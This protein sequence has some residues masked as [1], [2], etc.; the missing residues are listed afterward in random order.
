MKD[1]E[2][3]AQ[4][5]TLRDF[6]KTP[7]EIEA[8]LKRVKA[9]G[10]NYV[11]VSGIGAISHE[12]MRRILDQTGLKVCATH[13]SFDRIKSN[14]EEVIYQHRLWECPNIGIGMMPMEYNRSETGYTK[15][16]KEASEIGKKLAEYGFRF[17]YHNHKVEFEKYNG[18][19]ALDILADE[20]SPS[21]FDFILDTYW[22]QAGG[23]DPVEWI[24]K[25]DGRMTCIHFKDMKIKEDKQ[26]MSEVGEGSMIWDRIIKACR[27]TGVRWIAVEQD[28]CNGKDPFECLSISYNNL[29]NMLQV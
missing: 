3:A 25:M 13:I 21:Q 11:Q 10:Y 4:L 28:D 7:A 18:R 1:M 14:I 8:T 19:L 26:L 24:Y 12:E 17:T 2:L 22:I 15:F 20:S 5:F 23:G 6:L 16:A 29:R 9:I 27:D